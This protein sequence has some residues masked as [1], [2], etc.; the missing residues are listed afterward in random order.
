MLLC[1]FDSVLFS[2][3]LAMRVGVNVWTDRV[4]GEIEIKPISAD[5]LLQIAQAFCGTIHS[6]G[7]AQISPFPFEVLLQKKQKAHHQSER[8]GDQKHILRECKETKKGQEKV[9][10]G[11]WASSVLAVHEREWGK[12]KE[13]K[14]VGLFQRV[15]V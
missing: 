14:V 8:G 13:V 10:S 1:F 4:R 15:F 6:G 12:E 2:R 11:L 9:P 7:K 5:C 3:A